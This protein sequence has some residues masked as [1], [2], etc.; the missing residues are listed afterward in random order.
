MSVM[1]GHFAALP[2]LSMTAAPA[3]R[4]L[5]PSALAHLAP[6][7]RFADTGKYF[8][9][10]GCG[11]RP[12][13]CSRCQ[14]LLKRLGRYVGEN[15]PGT[16][17]VAQPARLLLAHAESIQRDAENALD[18]RPD[19]WEASANSSRAARKAAIAS[20]RCWMPSSR[21]PSQNKCKC[22]TVEIAGRLQCPFNRSRFRRGVDS[23]RDTQR[24]AM[25]CVG[26][27]HGSAVSELSACCPSQ[28]ARCSHS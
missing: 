1:S 15:L 10:I 27:R 7:N 23:D 5:R 25:R 9:E 24:R 22:A 4:S 8:P 11:S 28:Q 20:V 16:D 14:Q 12:R 18:H 3:R 26:W 21:T 19:E 2:A 13:P 6:S 17:V